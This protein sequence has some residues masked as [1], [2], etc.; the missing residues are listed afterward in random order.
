MKYKTR[1]EKIGQFPNE[2]GM[3]LLRIVCLRGKE[4]FF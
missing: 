1:E 3:V 2:N 4:K